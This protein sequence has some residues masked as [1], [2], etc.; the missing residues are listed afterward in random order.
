MVINGSIYR[1]KISFTEICSPL[2]R[3]KSLRLEPSNTC[4][5]SDKHLTLPRDKGLHGNKMIIYLE[6]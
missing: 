4:I 6:A 3:K 2:N 5:W 1:L